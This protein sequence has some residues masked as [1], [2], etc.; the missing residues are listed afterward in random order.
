MKMAAEVARVSSQD[1]RHGV[2]VLLCRSLFFGASVVL[3]TAASPSSVFG[4]GSPAADASNPVAAE[5]ASGVKTVVATPS[6]ETPVSATVRWGA[7]VDAVRASH[8]GKPKREATTGP[9][10]LLVYDGSIAGKTATLVY[11][12]ANGELFETSYH[13]RSSSE[14]CP[15][16]EASFDEVN[17]TLATSLN[18]QPA[19]QT[20]AKCD[21]TVRWKTDDSEVVSHL[22]GTAAEL[23]HTIMFSAR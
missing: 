3:G 10:T 22:G 1:A 11:R 19:E 7:S 15:A 16:A 14:G 13:L 12:F 9:A 20:G 18:A 8:S 5:P 23:H 6:A 2:G 21:R 4:E 17:R